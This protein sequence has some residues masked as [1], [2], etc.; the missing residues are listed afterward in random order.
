[1]GDIQSESKLVWKLVKDILLLPFTLV[2]VLFGRKTIG[3]LFQPIKD[4][5]AFLFEAKV[6]ITLVILN[7][8]IFF[9]LNLLFMYG[10]I[11]ME[12]IESYF[13]DTPQRFLSLNFLPI[14]GSWFFHGSLLHLLG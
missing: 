3:D 9:G 10:Y 12:F 8:A 1:M 6:T 5:I 13:I 7:V 11:T 2:L 14:V 4:L